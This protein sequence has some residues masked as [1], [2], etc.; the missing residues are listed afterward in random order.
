MVSF[1]MPGVYIEEI[2]ARQK[3][4]EGLATSITAFIGLN[5]SAT[6]SDYR[7]PIAS[8][9]DFT[10]IFG[11]CSDMQSNGKVTLLNYLG[12]AVQSFFENGGRKCYVA[13][14]PRLN[15]NAYREALESLQTIDE[16]CLI[17]APGYSALA[18]ADASQVSQLLV[19]HAEKRHYCFA[20]LDS[21]PN[22]SNQQLLHARQA[23]HSA[24][25]ALYTPWLIVNDSRRDKDIL[26]PP[27]G[28][29]AGVL[30]RVDM[31]YGVWK[32]PSN[33][34][35]RG[36][37]G[38]ERYIDH[39]EQ[40][41]LAPRGINVLR[42]V[43]ARG[44]RIWGIRTTSDDEQWRYVPVKRLA[45]YIEHSILKGIDWAVFE[46]NEEPLWASVQ[47]EISLF[48]EKLWRSGAFQ[49]A[50]ANEAYFV[51]VDR[52]TMTERDI[53]EGRMYMEVGFAPLKPAEFVVLRLRLKTKPGHF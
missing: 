47:G 26:I 49:G 8:Y 15:V 34:E 38:F 18:E 48:L 39:I 45:M 28:A 37:I 35:I 24:N 12:Y 27:S 31:N 17:A 13:A 9:Q 43:T 4:I 53:L 33:D 36:I 41:E 3:P 51:R 52:A 22:A 10:A 46:P 11:E 30:A 21:P 23:I 16:I 14:V 5:S 2:S 42:N 19:D 20:L 7:R 6:N 50:H 40:S 44:Y 32:A 1:L 29:V 25:A